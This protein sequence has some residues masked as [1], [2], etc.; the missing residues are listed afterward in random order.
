LSLSKAPE[1]F[2]MAGMPPTDLDFKTGD[3][4]TMEH[5][6]VEELRADGR[7]VSLIGHPPSG[8][9]PLRVRWLSLERP[10]K[11]T[12]RV[13]ATRQDLLHQYTSGCDLFGLPDPFESLSKILQETVAGS[14]SIIHGDLNLENVL[15]GPGGLVWLIDFARTREGHTLFD[16]AHLEAEVIAHILAPQ[17]E[18][19]QEY[20]DLLR[21]P[22]N[23]QFSNLYDLRLSLHSMANRCLFNP[24]Q[25]R[26]YRLASVL[27]CLGAL[28]FTNLDRHAKHLLYLTAA[29]MLQEL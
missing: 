18:S 9:P 29:F 28:K 1:K 24:T 2:W 16:F 15:L 6:D 10:E 26:E 27:T 11:A 19:A 23:S 22:T 3:V 17:I 12:G 5:F 25:P 14:R 7:S 13:V 20:L 8:Q 21:D 4:L